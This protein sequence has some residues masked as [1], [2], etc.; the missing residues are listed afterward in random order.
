MSFCCCTDDGAEDDHV[1]FSPQ[2]FPRLKKKCN[3]ISRRDKDKILR[4]SIYQSRNDQEW[5][6]LLR[7]QNMIM[8]RQAYQ[9]NIEGVIYHAA[10]LGRDDHFIFSQ[11][12]ENATHLHDYTYD[13]LS[14]DSRNR[15]EKDEQYMKKSFEFIGRIMCRTKDRGLALGYGRAMVY[16]IDTSIFVPTKK[17][18]NI[19]M[20]EIMSL[21][22]GI[23]HV[24]MGWNSRKCEFACVYGFTSDG[25]ALNYTL[26]HN[27]LREEHP[28]VKLIVSATKEVLQEFIF[29]MMSKFQ[30]KLVVKE[31]Y[32]KSKKPNNVAQVW[33]IENEAQK[34]RQ[35][36]M[37]AKN[38]WQIL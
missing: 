6:E 30:L 22:G 3:A 36:H 28:F 21:V 7:T 23:R 18:C 15:M 29:P 20:T 24:C 10:A 9:R 12:F 17:N 16:K 25:D 31:R 37:R 38:P 4:I 19:L 11:E 26:K 35:K 13:F 33:E 2:S 34:A 14:Q 32:S 8:N 1:A 5:H 27:I